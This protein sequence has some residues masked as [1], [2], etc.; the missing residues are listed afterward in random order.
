MELLR[1]VII[2]LKQSL[3]AVDRTV[4]LIEAVAER[5]LAE[6]RWQ[7]RSVARA[8]LSSLADSRVVLPEQV[9]AEILRSS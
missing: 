6:R 9:S 3:D 8:A 5:E 1:A 7:P 2:R 4:A